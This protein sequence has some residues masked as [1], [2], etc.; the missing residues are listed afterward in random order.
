MTVRT[1]DGDALLA[2]ARVACAV[3]PTPDADGL[4][5][6]YLELL[7]L[8]LC[9]LTGATTRSVGAMADGTVMSRELRGDAMRL[10]AA[11]M[12][13]PHQGLT[14]IG[15]RRLDDLQACV[16]AIV[17][18][19]VPG[20]LIEAGA[21]RGGA[22]ILMRATL[23]ALGDART[24]CVADSFT[25]FPDDAAGDL[26]GFDFLAVPLEEVRASFARHGLK[27][28]VEF[29][30]GFFEDTLPALAG[31]SWA[32]VRLDAD[33]Y[34]PTRAALEALYPGLVPGGY[35]IVD[36]YGSFPE[37]RRAVDEFRARHRINERL[38]TIDFTAA[39]WR[40]ESADRIVPAPGPTRPRKRPVE[41][42]GQQHVPTAEEVELARVNA[43]LRA[44]VAAL[45]AEIRLLRGLRRR[46]AWRRGR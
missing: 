36:D 16:E 45:E 19:G 38:E 32:I 25:G 1:Q 11:G 3:A 4:R 10:R 21:W 31:R 35:L 27:R 13:W 39:R 9:D 30:P 33:T 29:V 23:D 17:R 34:E 28:G 14:M 20:D 40:R 44:R 42:P 15:L 2:S 12:D 37:C 46:L 8:C 26:P 22:S 7:K 41:R 18:E 24:V 5:A 6:A 43:E